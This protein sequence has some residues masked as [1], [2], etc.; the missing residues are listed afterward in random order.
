MSS[1]TKLQQAVRG[2]LGL[3][4]GTL[5]LGVSPGAL[6]QDAVDE[7]EEI[8]VT[9][10]RIKRADLG[11]ASPITVLD[12]QDLLSFGLTD[13]G[14]L[15]QRMP[16]MSGSPIGTTTNNGNTA[17]GVVEIDLRGMGPDRTVTLIN[18]KRVVDGGD[19]H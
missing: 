19:Y 1:N 18:G 2:A 4:V 13:V 3:S 9:G 14:N 7:L 12:R 8:V 5:A 15:L 10:S 16:S 11:S 17:E 6:A